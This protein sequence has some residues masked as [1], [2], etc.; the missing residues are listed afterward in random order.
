MDLGPIPAVAEHKAESSC[1]AFAHLPTPARAAPSAGT[2]AMS[3]ACYSQRV[4]A[5]QMCRILYASAAG[6]AGAG[7]SEALVSAIRYAAA[8]SAEV[9]KA[10]ASP[11]DWVGHS[12]R[13][14]H[15]PI[16]NVRSEPDRKASILQKKKFGSIVWGVQLDGWVKLDGEPGF[17]MIASSEG[18]LLKRT[19]E[20]KSIQVIKDHG[21]S[22]PL[23]ECPWREHLAQFTSTRDLAVVAGVSRA[24]REEL[25]VEQEHEWDDGSRRRLLAPLV[26]LKLETAEPELQRVSMPHCRT[27]RVWSRLSVNAAGRE[28]ARGGADYVRS[29]EKLVIKGCPLHTTDV[30][31]LL[32]PVLFMAARLTTLNLEKNQLQDATIQGLVASGALEATQS[33]ESIN[34]RFNRV[35]DAGAIALAESPGVARLK[36]M[37]LKMNSIS[38]KGALALAR[39]LKDNRSMTLINLRKQCPG[40]T[41]TAARGFAETLR[42]TSVLEQLRLR[43]NKCTDAG[44]VVLAEAMAARFGNCA[45]PPAERLELDLEDNRIK[46]VG[47]L[48]LLKAAAVVPK[49]IR[50]EVLLCGNASTWA[51]LGAAAQETEQ[52]S[53]DVFDAR[54]VFDSKSEAAL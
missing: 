3:D 44:A 51:S 34:I 40:L 54:L 18:T 48:A 20:V 4:L 24:A 1:R 11:L 30:N 27:L 19:D 52:G 5:R 46:D 33:L 2:I 6:V 36:W 26:E 42:S 37:N 43:R 38:D 12:W 53:V 9:C 32:E 7:E 16:C 10:Q 14:V 49:R 8:V 13:V 22:L 29:M 25:T 31:T 21:P 28:V 45:V 35:S 23:L 15:R 17:M 39:M 50:I 41:D 47:A